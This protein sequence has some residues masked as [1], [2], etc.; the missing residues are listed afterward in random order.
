MTKEFN[1]A[2]EFVEFLKENETIKSILP[3]AEELISLH[4]S[5][6][7]GCACRKNQ[8]IDTRDHVYKTMLENTISNNKDLQDSLKKYS[9]AT[10]IV[11]RGPVKTGADNSKVLLK[12]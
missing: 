9:G 4:G 7:K 6:G 12:I 8:R 3:F 10:A 2:G 5:I 11:W 1:D